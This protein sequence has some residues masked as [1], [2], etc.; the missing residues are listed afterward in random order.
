MRQPLQEFITPV[1]V[2]HSLGDDRAQRGHALGQPGRD[3]AAVKG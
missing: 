1:V 3:A 2:N